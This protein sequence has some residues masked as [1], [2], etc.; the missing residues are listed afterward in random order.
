[1]RI[2]DWSSDVCSSD[3]LKKH[4]VPPELVELEVTETVFAERG[5]YYVGRALQQLHDKGI[6]IAL[7]DFGT[8][9]SSLSHLRDFPVDVVKIDRSFVEIGR[10]QCRERVCQ[11]V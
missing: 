6:R 11:N 5:S 2:S 7:D 4:G 1:M 8:G 10:A 9:Y 3:L